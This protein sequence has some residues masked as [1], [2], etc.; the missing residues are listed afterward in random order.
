MTETKVKTIP[1]NPIYRPLLIRALEEE[2]VTVDK[3]VFEGNPTA[4]LM[5]E[6]GYLGFF[7]FQ[8]K[9]NFPYLDH[10]V[11]F[12][13]RRSYHNFY[14]MWKEFCRMMICMGYMRFMSNAPREKEH[15]KR[16]YKYWTGKDEPYTSKDGNDF[17]I[18]PVTRKGVV[19]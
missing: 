12:K 8:I 4:I 9:D 14:V 19:A 18:M 11:I 5:D 13:N 15:L 17:Y 3:M 2:G 10:F 7:S 6:E 1:Y 16:F